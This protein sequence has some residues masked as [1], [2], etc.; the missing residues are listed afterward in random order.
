MKAS[1]GASALDAAIA[2]YP[3]LDPDRLLAKLRGAADH[4][5]RNHSKARHGLALL[6]EKRDR[7]ERLLAEVNTQ[8]AEA[9]AAAIATHEQSVA[10]SAALELFEEANR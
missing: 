1:A 10:A 5:D 7:F 8:V 2:T 3:N 9:E 6:R 4:A